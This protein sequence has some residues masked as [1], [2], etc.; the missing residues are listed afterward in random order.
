MVKMTKS[1][2]QTLPFASFEWKIAF[3]YLRSKKER[4]LY[5]YYKFVFIGWHNVGRSHS[6]YCPCC[7]EWF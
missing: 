7:Y 2:K 1:N 3:R 4:R 6:N 5:I